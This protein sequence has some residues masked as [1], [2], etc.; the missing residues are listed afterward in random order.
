MKFLDTKKRVI[1]LF[2]PEEVLRMT[3][4]A[5]MNSSYHLLMIA[6]VKYHEM[7]IETFVI[8]KITSVNNAYLK[9]SVKFHYDFN[10]YF[11]VRK[12]ETQTGPLR[13]NKSPYKID[14]GHTNFSL[15]GQDIYPLNTSLYF[16]ETFNKNLK[17]AVCYFQ[18]KIVIIF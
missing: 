7:R 12:N 5:D 16:I 18:L 3:K 11:R 14:F 15:E 6:C 17:L 9:K 13:E 2:E 1:P 4:R 8:K 10:Y